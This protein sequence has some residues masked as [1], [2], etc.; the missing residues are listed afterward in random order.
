MAKC[1]K[2]GLPAKARGLCQKHYHQI[3][4]TLPASPTRGMSDE[5]RFWYYTK[6]RED[7]CWL[8][9]GATTGRYGTL[10]F[11]GKNMGAHRASLL[12]HGLNIP[13]GASVRS[14]CSNLLCVNPN[15][16][17]LKVTGE[18]AKCRYCDTPAKARG[19]C[20]KHYYRE[21]STHPVLKTRDMSDRER[22]FHHVEKTPA[23]WLW[24]AAK[25]PR[26]GSFYVDGRNKLAHRYSYE[27]HKGRIPKGLYV[28]HTCD[29]PS[30][31]NPDHLFLG[32]AKDN[33]DDMMTKGRGMWP[34]GTRHHLSRLSDDDVTC[35]RS[36]KGLQTQSRLAAKF[37]VDQSHISRIMHSQKRGRVT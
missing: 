25:T 12:I 27:I 19:L 23:C 7:G 13:V 33:T 34:S 6:R 32:S 21:T 9:V 2:C 30:C 37:G 29:N 35:I 14:S 26:Y 8:W 22:F 31:V 36:Q 11:M 4:K 20:Q 28:C 16:L 3:V 5:Q 24:T 15:H 18:K 10:R 17:F 1:R